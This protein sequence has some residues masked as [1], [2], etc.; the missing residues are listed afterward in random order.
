MSIKD[1]I[2][3]L[4]KIVLS[5]ELQAERTTGRMPS[6]FLPSEDWGVIK[7]LLQRD[8]FHHEALRGTL[9][10]PV[11]TANCA[12][13]RSLKPGDYYFDP[14]AEAQYI[15]ANA[16]GYKKGLGYE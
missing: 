15:D 14:M 11:E 10:N 9:G 3:Q 16:L 7:E 6:I 4:K 12:G 2:E 5:L 1:R 8:I 13:T